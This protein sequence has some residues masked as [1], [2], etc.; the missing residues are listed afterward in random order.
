[1]TTN[2]ELNL[3]KACVLTALLYGFETWTTYRHHVNLLIR[4]HQN[5]IRRILNI[6]WRVYTRDTGFLERAC[7]TSIEKRL[8]LNQVRW[9]G[10]AVRMADG[11][12]S[13]QIFYGELT[14]GIRSQ[15]K[16]KQRFKDV[17][18]N[19]NSMWTTGKH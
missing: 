1:M 12:L 6:E 7:S 4:F 8:I 13:K 2:T 15:H 16:P 14:G 9:A 11:G 19:R 3:Y 10:H 18:K 17:S 5:F